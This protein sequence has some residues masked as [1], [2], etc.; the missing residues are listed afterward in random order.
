[1]KNDN[2]TLGGITKMFKAGGRQLARH[3]AFLFF[4]LLAIIYSYII[5]S[6]NDL[7]GISPDQ[8]TLSKSPSATTQP[9]IDPKVVQKL[10]SLQ[11][12]SVNVQ[13]LFNQARQNPFEE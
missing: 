10:Q 4:V 11:D 6:I 7:S 13:T 3:S 1:M 5:F 12:N 9:H 8:A 2:I